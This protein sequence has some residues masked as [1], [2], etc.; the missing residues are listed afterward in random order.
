MLL[1]DLMQEGNYPTAVPEQFHGIIT[2]VGVPKEAQKSLKALGQDVHNAYLRGA[3]DYNIDEYCM[4][5]DRLPPKYLTPQEFLLAYLRSPNAM[6]N[7]QRCDGF[8]TLSKFQLKEAGTKKDKS[9]PTVTPRVGDWYHIQIPGND[10][11]VMIVDVQLGTVKSSATVQTMT[12]LQ[13]T[14]INDDHPVSGRRQFGIESLGGEARG[15]YRFYTR[16][17]DRQTTWLQDIQVSNILQHKSFKRL[18]K[19]MAQ[20]HS[21][22]AER[23]DNKWGWVRQIPAKVLLSS[24]TV[25]NPR[26]GGCW[27]FTPTC[28]AEIGAF[29]QHKSAQCRRRCCRSRCCCCF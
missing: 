20:E 13:I 8:E 23:P 2:G 16:G 1:R 5:L 6:A 28:F 27:P 24:V 25:R 29:L 21:G 3:G 26:T 4:I 17:F 19:A 10:G 15:P 11:D 12:D 14:G 22:R 9:G 7:D 18:M